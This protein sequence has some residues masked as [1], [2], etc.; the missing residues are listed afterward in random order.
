MSVIT[1]RVVVSNITEVRR[2]FNKIKIYRSV[3]GKSGTYAEITEALSRLTLDSDMIIYEYQDYSGSADYYY[4]SSYYNSTTG[5]E[6]S[7]SDP[8][9]GEG[10]PAL[11]IISVAELKT[12]YLFGLDLTNDS[13][14]EY[15]DSLYEY[16][17]KSAVSWIEHK[18]DIDLRPVVRTE[19]QDW[20]YDDYSKWMALYVDHFPI[21][22]VESV[23]LKLPGGQ[24]IMTYENDWLQVQKESGQIHIVPGDAAGVLTFVGQGS[25]LP[26]MNAHKFIPNAWIIQ[27]TSGFSPDS[28]P[29]ILRDL[30]GKT[31]SFGP[32]NIAGDLLGGAGIAS[33][34]ISMDGLSQSFNTT[35]SATSAGY[36]A[37]LLQYQKEIK[38]VIPTL[39]RYYKG[40]RISVV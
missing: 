13:G 28:V 22:A 30:V 36:G 34:S 35:S 1:V 7:L 16:F 32:L 19:Y 29:D 3:A 15:P 4:R 5:V 2:F 27:Y 39:R 26:L 25:V 10:D 21:I 33:Q 23:T 31:A 24:V 37:R 14:E 12:N 8:Q 11:D 9:R 6:S 20:N 40:A 18:L 38:E 17:I